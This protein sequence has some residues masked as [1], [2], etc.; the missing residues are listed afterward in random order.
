M[1]FICIV[2]LVP[3]VSIMTGLIDKSFWDTHVVQAILVGDGSVVEPRAFASLP[4]I[5]AEHAEVGATA[6]GHV[7]TALLKF[8]HCSAVVTA[9]PSLLFG[10]VDKPVGLRIV[11]T[12]AARVEL[13]VAQSAHL[14]LAS[15]A[16]TVLATV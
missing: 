11:G 4:G 8:D 7:V 13:V 10:H 2:T 3:G 14:G 1:S 6:A 16:A 9:L 15:R 12:L 5:G